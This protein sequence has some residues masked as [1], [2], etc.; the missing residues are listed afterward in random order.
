[1]LTEK[2]KV[3]LTILA[4]G[5]VSLGF[6]TVSKDY[7]IEP[8][9]SKIQARVDAQIPPRWIDQ[10]DWARQMKTGFRALTSDKKT[11]LQQIGDRISDKE[12][13]FAYFIDWDYK[14]NDSARRSLRKDIH[15]SE[16]GTPL[17]AAE[18]LSAL[19]Q[20]VGAITSIAGVF[21]GLV[22]ASERLS[23]RTGFPIKIEPV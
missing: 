17:R 6:G 20:I 8:I 14:L 4:F 13:A 7:L 19:T 22:V 2:E 12:L 11:T 10:I 5:V 16:Y 3:S 15:Q 1:M 18:S 9:N 23:R 21:T